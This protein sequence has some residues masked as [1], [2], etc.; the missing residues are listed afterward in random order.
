MRP[1]RFQVDIP[2]STLEDLE[3]RCVSVNRPTEF[4]DES[5]EYGV[6]GSYSKQLCAYWRDGFDWH[7]QEAGIDQYPHLGPRLRWRGRGAAAIVD[8]SSS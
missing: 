3:R 8:I 2:E 4:D 1:V 5:W 6:P 7:A